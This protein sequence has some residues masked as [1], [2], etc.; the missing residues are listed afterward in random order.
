MLAIK[1]ISFFLWILLMCIPLIPQNWVSF[2]II[3][4]GVLGLTMLEKNHFTPIR[5]FYFLLL[6]FPFF[7]YLMQ[8]MITG[9]SQDWFLVEKANSYW[10]FPFLI[11]FS[12]SMPSGN[13]MKR[14]LLIFSINMLIVA[15]GSS[16][17]LL[18]KGLSVFPHIPAD[19]ISIYREN[20]NRLLHIHPSYLSIMSA[21]AIFI[22][23]DDISIINKRLFIRI[24]AVL[25]LL[26]FMF[27]LSARLVWAALITSG[28]WAIVNLFLLKKTA[29]KFVIAS[30]ILLGLISIAFIFNPRSHELFSFRE[31]AAHE[32]SVTVRSIIYS[33]SF[34]SAERHF[35]LGA[36]SQI[37]Q[38]ELSDCY[39]DTPVFRLHQFNTHNQYLDFLISFGI[40]GLMVLIGIFGFSFYHAIHSKQIIY[41]SFLLLFLI[42]LAGENMLSRQAGIVF[43]SLFNSWFLAL[44]LNESSNR[45]PRSKQF[46]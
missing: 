37:I 16:L 13:Q 27:F 22:L 25:I 34:K 41:S 24:T 1:K 5:I 20:I 4:W 15:I 35:G 30:S 10:V 42:C 2:I 19:F 36:P 43:F 17:F 8:A 6:A 14:L 11:L 7:F 40:F 28:I 39:G 12:H 31:D 44:S 3:A 32:N 26:V 9:E 21:F 38:K 23:L 33:C 46:V 29:W 45:K 18:V